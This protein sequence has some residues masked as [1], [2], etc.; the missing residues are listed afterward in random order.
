MHNHNIESIKVS[1]IISAY[2]A[3]RYIS[4]SLDSIINQTHQNLEIIIINDGSTDNTKKICLEYQKKDPRIIFIDKENEG[5]TKSLNK[6]IKLATGAWIARQDADDISLT[7]RIESQL[8]FSIKNKIDF[9][10]SKALIFPSSKKNYYIPK[11]RSNVA[12][13]KKILKYGNPHIHGTF[14]FKKKIIEKI[15]Y[16][17]KIKYAQDFNFILAVKSLGFKM[18]LLERPLYKLRI[19]ENSISF[20]KRNEQ[21]ESVRNSLKK[22]GYSTSYIIEENNGFKKLIIRALKQCESIF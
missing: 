8:S 1:I 20:K 3:E 2:N 11:I 6:G 5:L 4:E 15:I 17:E 7:N 22:Y 10:T 21:I 9:C 16:D 12:F 13:K 18:A 14:F 19:H